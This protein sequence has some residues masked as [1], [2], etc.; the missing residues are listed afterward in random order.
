MKFKL[1]FLAFFLVFVM[2][3]CAPK[4][5]FGVTDKALTPPSAFEQTEVAIANA[6]QSEGAKYCP[7]KIAQ[8][9]EL[10][11]KAAETFWACRTCE[12]LNMLENARNLAKEAESCQP[13][14]VTPPPPPA[15]APKPALPTSLPSAYFDFDDATLRPEGE[16]K[17]DGVAVYMKDNPGIDVEIQGHTCSIGTEEYNMRLGQKRADSAAEYLKAKGTSSSRIRTVSFG[18]SRPIATNTT[19]EGRA[20]NRRVDLIPIQ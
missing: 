12:S 1:T 14:K 4:S 6:E 16:A 3:G 9:R 18:E 17:L 20:Q 5:H 7:E 15:P 11:K 8:A 10:A 13:P 19:R 2:V